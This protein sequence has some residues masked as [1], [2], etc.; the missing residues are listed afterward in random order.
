MVDLALQARRGGVRERCVEVAGDDDWVTNFE[1]VGKRLFELLHAVFGIRSIL[2]MGRGHG[3]LSTGQVGYV[4][5]DVQ[6][7]PSSPTHLAPNFFQEDI[8]RDRPLSFFQQ[9]YP[10]AFRRVPVVTDGQERVEFGVADGVASED[11][12]TVKSADALLVDLDFLNRFLALGFV[13]QLLE[14]LGPQAHR[15]DLDEFHA[16]GPVHVEGDAEFANDVAIA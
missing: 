6:C 15:I 12:R 2:K 8:C 9:A 7:G 5:L 4:Q 1:Q 11:G 16:E 10:V 3:Q 14:W 13:F